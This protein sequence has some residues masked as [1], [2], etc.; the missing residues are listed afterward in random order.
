MTARSSPKHSNRRPA[1]PASTNQ[2]HST[3]SNKSAPVF[4]VLAQIPSG[5]VATYGQVAN[6]AGMPG[7]AR[8]VGYCLRNLPEGS[9]LP[10]HRVVAAGGRIALA[11]GSDAFASQLNKLNQEGIDLRNGKVDMKRFQWRC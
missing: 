2:S 9:A 3:D 10:W 7:A 11:E 6:L 4:Q 1:A 5:C 8:Y